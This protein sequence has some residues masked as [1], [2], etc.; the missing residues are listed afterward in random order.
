MHTFSNFTGHASPNYFALP[1]QVRLLSRSG[2]PR[3]D[4]AGLKRK[5]E[6]FGET[7]GVYS[8]LSCENYF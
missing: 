7:K 1:F 8:L 5:S 3:R 6:I 4:K 2:A